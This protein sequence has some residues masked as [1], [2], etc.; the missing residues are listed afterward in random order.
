VNKKLSKKERCEIC[1]YNK[2]LEIHHINGN[3]KNNSEDNLIVLCRN[4]HW[5]IHHENEKICKHK[6]AVKKVL[7]KIKL[8]GKQAEVLKLECTYCRAEGRIVRWLSSG[9]FVGKLLV[10]NR[11]VQDWE[12]L[13]D[14]S[15]TTSAGKS[16]G[17]NEKKE[18]EEK[19]EW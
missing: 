6:W 14:F 2:A 5:L 10:Y 17:E 15:I 12:I 11:T 9:D 16:G 4:C 8:R 13:K 18:E 7:R 1:G 3:R 19:W